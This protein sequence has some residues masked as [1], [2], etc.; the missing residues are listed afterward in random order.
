MYLNKKKTILVISISAVVFFFTYTD[1]RSQDIKVTD[2]DT[3]KIDGEKIR[4]SGIDTP[5]LKQTCIKDRVKNS[6]G[7]KAK[8]ILIDKISNNKVNCITEGKDQYKRTLA[9][10]FVNSESLSSYLVKSGYA[11]AYRKYSKKFIKDEDYARMKK[12]GM[13]SMKFEYPWEYRKNN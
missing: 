13:W 12:I 10:C 5:E 3:I 6:C 11:F 2:G 4:F 9:E 1:I 8:Q 7:I